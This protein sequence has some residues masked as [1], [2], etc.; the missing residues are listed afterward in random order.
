MDLWHFMTQMIPDWDA[1]PATT[2]PGM[3]GRVLRATVGVGTLLI[4][5]YYESLLLQYLLV[6]TR[7]GLAR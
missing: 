4:V 2:D 1:P 7:V 5:A 6:Y 3:T